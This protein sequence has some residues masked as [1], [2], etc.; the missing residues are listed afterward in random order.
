MIALRT[1]G[2]CVVACVSAAASLGAQTGGTKAA[3]TKVPP[4]RE[5]DTNS[6]VRGIV[7]DSSG[8]PLD[9]IE[10]YVVTSGRSA[11]T[12]SAGRYAIT[13]LIEGPTQLRARRVGWKAADTTL[14]VTPQSEFAVN[15]TLGTHIAAL[16]T[17]RVT[18]SQDG[19]APRAIAGFA[20]RRKAG[21]GVYRD[22]IEIAALKPETLADMLEGING[23]RRDGATVEATTRWRCLSFLVNGHPPMPTELM[24]IKQKW[25]LKNTVAFEFYED[26]NTAPEWYKVF[27]FGGNIGRSQRAPCSLIVFW[28]KGSR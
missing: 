19:C 4:R 25:W 16:D 8:H 20:C 2:A 24:W 1:V 3:A 23:L 22:S 10:V 17:I 7:H 11:R 5:S 6:V 13:N 27:A 21:V 9:S 12:D 18:S 14:V 26:A 28:L 15:F